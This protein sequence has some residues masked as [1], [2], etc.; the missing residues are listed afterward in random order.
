M[1]KISGPLAAKQMRELGYVGAII[2][3]TG[4]AYTAEFLNN[5]ANMVLMKPI[6][7][8]E[9]LDAMEHVIKEGDYTPTSAKR[10]NSMSLNRT[11]LRLSLDKRDSRDL[12]DSL[13]KLNIQGTLSPRVSRG[14]QWASE[15][16]GSR[17]RSE[18]SKD[19]KET[20]LSLNDLMM[21]M[22]GKS[23][24]DDSAEL[25]RYIG[26]KLDNESSKNIPSVRGN[27]YHSGKISPCN[28]EEEI[29][30][31]TPSSKILSFIIPSRE[32][33]K[34]SPLDDQS[35]FAQASSGG[36]CNGS[37]NS[38]IDSGIIFTPRPSYTLQVPMLLDVLVNEEDIP[39]VIDIAPML[40]ENNAKT[41]SDLAVNEYDA[42]TPM[43]PE[44]NATSIRPF[45]SD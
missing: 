9:L 29:S 36:V 38:P 28:E 27:N 23:V 19:S 24:P 26:I 42:D 21:R 16:K 33:R 30:Q 35:F 40:Q 22:S 43:L 10:A 1:P 32:S 34:I 20:K 6:S 31:R 3:I 12:S 44:N 5:G 37:I 41:I 7:R 14:S 17:E 25:S 39:M 45:S 13:R 4:D 18:N 11:Q 2:G 15:S 8:K